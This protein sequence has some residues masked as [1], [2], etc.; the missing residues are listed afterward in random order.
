M[1]G[2]EH[3]QDGVRKDFLEHVSKYQKQSCIDMRTGFLRS[4]L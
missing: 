2:L 3:G 4:F 1:R